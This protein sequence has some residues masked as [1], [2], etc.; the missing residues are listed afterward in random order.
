MEL[1]HAT[2]AITGGA[3]GLGLGMAKILGRKGATIVIIDIQKSEV[4]QAKSALEAL[5]INAAAYC[6]NVAD[7]PQ[8]DQIFKQIV[9]D[10]GELN[11]LI[12]N[13][14]ILRDSLLIKTK[15]G[16]ATNRMSLAQWQ[17]VIDVNLTGVFLC[18]RAAAEQMINHATKGVII[19]IS[20]IAKSGNIGQSNYA[21]AKAGVAALA[22]TWAQELGRY[23]IRCAAIAPGFVMTDMVASMKP[24]ILG[25][26][27]SRIPVGRMG[28]I[29]EIAEAAAFILCNDYFNGRVLEMDGGLRF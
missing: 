22:T 25:K 8:V 15:D 12:N 2:I 9:T 27:A 26:M 3:R 17:A 5:G 21:A 7:E 13:A 16:Q 6:C 10:H 20:S 18:G 1:N 24:D 11:A 29:A 4:D 28:D 19:N 23:G 14:G